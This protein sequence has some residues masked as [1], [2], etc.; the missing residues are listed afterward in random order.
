MKRIERWLIEYPVLPGI[1][2]LRHISSFGK[3]DVCKNVIFHAFVFC[4][5]KRFSAKRSSSE[6]KS[7]KDCLKELSRMKKRELNWISSS[8]KEVLRKDI[9]SGIVSE[10]TPAEVLYNMHNGI[11]HAFPLKNFKVNLK[12]LVAAIQ[13]KEQNAQRDEELLQN[14]LKHKP[15]NE[16]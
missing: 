8:Q 2:K 15:N 9:M 1:K 3:E 6:T 5:Q 10:T 16:V 11:Y 12:N 4:I 13:K 14:T 7:N